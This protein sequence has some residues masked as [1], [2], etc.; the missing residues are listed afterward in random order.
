MVTKVVGGYWVLPMNTN[1]PY[2]HR[3]MA[4]TVPCEVMIFAPKAA[5]ISH[6]IENNTHRLERKFNFY[7]PDSVLSTR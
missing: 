5:Q 4:M 1:Q 2:S 6:E 3:F 7:D